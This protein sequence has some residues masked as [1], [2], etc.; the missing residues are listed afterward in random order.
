MSKIEKNVRTMPSDMFVDDL[1]NVVLTEKK[2]ESTSTIYKADLKKCSDPKVG[3]LAKLRLIPQ[4]VDGK[5]VYI[6]EKE[7]INVKLDGYPDLSGAYDSKKNFP[8]ERCPLNQAQWTLKN[9][10]NVVEKER[11]S[12]LQ[13]YKKYYSLAIVEQDV[14]QPE[15]VGKVVVFSYGQKI[16]EKIQQEL[17]GTIN[18]KCNVFSLTKGKSMRLVVKQV[19]AWPNYDSTTF[20]TEAP[21]SLYDEAAHTFVKTPMVDGQITETYQKKIMDFLSN[22]PVSLS[23]FKAKPWSD[24]TTS[25]VNKIISIVMGGGNIVSTPPTKVSQSDSQTDEDLDEFFGKV[26][27]DE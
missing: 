19:G 12:C 25:K 9:S 16:R 27:E 6:V 20:L 3:Y 24:E 8:G 2:F 22:L 26:G 5:P 10:K 15:L 18:D 7:V 14:Q 4:L 11:A 17:D 13:W 1:S 21:I 23:D